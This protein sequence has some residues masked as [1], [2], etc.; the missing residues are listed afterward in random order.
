[1]TEE[2]ARILRLLGLGVRG[3][4]VV[5]GVE[6]VRKAVTAGKAKLAV[7]AADASQHSRDKIIPLLRARHVS[8]IEVASSGALG[9]AVGRETTAVVGV[10]DGQ[11][12]RGIHAAREEIGG[13]GE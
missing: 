2:A 1:M 5:V 7:V 12:A 4:L 13:Q 10:L 9:G 11:L 6:Q 3:G 8:M